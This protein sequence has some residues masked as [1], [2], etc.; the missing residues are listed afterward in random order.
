MLKT[1]LATAAI[2]LLVAF[3]ALWMFGGGHS[4]AV[5]EFEVAPV[6]IRIVDGPIP[7]AGCAPKLTQTAQSLTKS[8]P[9]CRP[10]QSCPTRID[11]ELTAALAAK[12][13]P[14]PYVRSGTMREIVKA[15]MPVADQVC[16][17]I[18]ATLQAQHNA[19]KCILPR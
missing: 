12:P 11:D 14:V 2:I 6:R 7:V 5:T 16:R 4:Y 17:A 15:P 18:V 1:A 8:C 3:G 9:T 10:V 13:L 19:A